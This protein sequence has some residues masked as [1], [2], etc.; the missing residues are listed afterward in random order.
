M[1]AHV[2]L[3]V[4]RNISKTKQKKY[5]NLKKQDFILPVVPS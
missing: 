3:R 1:L 4:Q 5:I 2:R